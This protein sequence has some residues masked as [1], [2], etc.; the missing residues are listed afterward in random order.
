[1]LFPIT[2]SLILKAIGVK[3]LLNLIIDYL[4]DKKKG[5]V[6]SGIFECGVS[7]ISLYKW[8]NTPVDKIELENRQQYID[9]I[10]STIEKDRYSDYVY[11]TDKFLD[12]KFESY[13]FNENASDIISCTLK[14]TGKQ[15]VRYAQYVY[16]KIIK[17]D[18]E[19]YG[20]M[21]MGHNIHITKYFALM[22]YDVLEFDVNAYSINSLLIMMKMFP[23]YAEYFIEGFLYSELN[24]NDIE[25]Y[26]KIHDTAIYCLSN[27]PNE[28]S[29][30]IDYYHEQKN[31]C[32]SIDL[33]NT[34]YRV[35]GKKIYLLPYFKIPEL[36]RID[37]RENYMAIYKNDIKNDVDKLY[38][39]VDLMI[40]CCDDEVYDEVY[41]IT[42]SIKLPVKNVRINYYHIK[43]CLSSNKFMSVLYRRND[44]YMLFNEVI[45]INYLCD[46]VKEYLISIGYIIKSDEYLIYKPV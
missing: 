1:M 12:Q 37:N 25:H 18:S 8:A 6:E 30:I 42:D 46:E 44:W 35:Y 11:I 38:Y 15:Y 26:R 9:L 13:R 29:D 7:C 32:E 34:I 36:Q 20:V 16:N 14:T 22:C 4:L 33:Y 5:P 43:E 24:D 2:S 27:Y 41:E 19:L 40:K 31:M 21:Y 10:F 28:L 39:Y 23:D 17:E 45:N 3:D